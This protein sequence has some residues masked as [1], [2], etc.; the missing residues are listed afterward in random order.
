MLG[1]SIQGSGAVLARGV[2]FGAALM[3]ATVYLGLGMKTRSDP[4][5]GRA[6]NCPLFS[7]FHGECSVVYKLSE[8]R[9]TPRPLQNLYDD[10]AVHDRAF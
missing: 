9:T 6:R 3:V 1:H 5:A 8:R 2:S 7:S 4:L 10:P